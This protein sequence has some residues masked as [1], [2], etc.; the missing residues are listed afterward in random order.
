[1]SGLLIDTLKEGLD[2]AV[3]AELDASDTLRHEAETY[4]QQLLV[5]EQLLSTETFT[6]TSDD[7]KATLTQEIAE[8]DLALRT[9]EIQLA[10]LTNEQRDLIVDVSQDLKTA[11]T[12]IA[13]RL[14]AELSAML[15]GLADAAHMRMD[16]RVADRLSAAIL[17]S[18]AVLM[19]IDA[20]LDILELPTLC[21]LCI[22]QGNYQEALEISTMVKML[23]IKF[24]AL[25]TFAQLDAQI[26]TELQLMVR[27][28]IKLLNTNLKQSNILKIFQILNRP[29]LVDIAGAGADPLSPALRERALK[30]IYLNSRFKF[31]HSEVSNL[32]PLLKLKKLTYLKRYIEV[33]REYLFNSL[34]IYYAIFRANTLDAHDDDDKFLIHSYVSSLAKMLV[35]KLRTHLPDVAGRADDDLD[36]SSQRDGVILQVIYLCKSLDKYGINFESTITWDLCLR[37]PV[38]ISESDWTRNL[39]KVKKFRS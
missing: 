9:I 29:D 36:L 7:N 28:L 24:P 37:E 17:G 12:K 19:N 14:G 34:S 6:T 27:G 10:A 2:P 11:S 38:L 23:R 31:I 39:A 32:A 26:R 1:M 18:N 5:S 30:I 25:A 35:E 33:Y 15:L 21:R 13:G 16:S 3:A 20:I 4:L 22:L 8:L